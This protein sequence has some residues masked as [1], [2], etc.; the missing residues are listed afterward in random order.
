MACP[1]TNIDHYKGM[2]QRDQN[3]KFKIVSDCP[4][5]RTIT[6]LA[7][8]NQECN[9]STPPHKVEISMDCFGLYC[10]SRVRSHQIG[11]LPYESTN[12]QLKSSIDQ[13]NTKRKLPI[14]LICLALK[15]S[16]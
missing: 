5:D 1:D 4:Y 14:E 6:I 10:S 11:I 13:I 12:F 16:N 15:L 2:I 3:K 8:V 7:G 9:I